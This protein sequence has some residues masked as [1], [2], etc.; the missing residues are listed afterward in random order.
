MAENF[1]KEKFGNITKIKVCTTT[2]DLNFD[3][4]T[5]PGTY[6]IYEDM[7]DG[8]SRIYFLT[9]DNSVTGACVKQTRI[10]CGTVE[11]RQTTTAGAWTAWEALSGGGSV[12]INLEN[13]EG[14]DSVVQTVCDPENENKPAPIATGTGAVALGRFNEAHGKCSMAV[15]YDNVV[16]GTYSFACGNGNFAEG[17]CTFV[18]GNKSKAQGSGAVAMG[19]ACVAEGDKSFAAGQNGASK[20]VGSCTIGCGNVASGDTSVAF[21][22]YNTVS[23]MYATSVGSRNVAE[24]RGSFIAG[25]Y[26]QT[27]ANWAAVFGVNNDYSDASNVFMIGCGRNSTYRSNVFEVSNKGIVR[28]KKTYATPSGAEVTL[29]LGDTAITETQL[30]T[31]LELLVS[32]ATDMGEIETALDS[33]IAIQNSLI[34]G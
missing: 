30:K 23:G 2:A 14:L 28:I 22:N 21:G 8:R 19:L 10:Y 12:S 7:G 11:T 31:L 1:F 18:S 34:G 9:V 16:N 5:E 17:N 3:T 33:I 4:Y 27:P 29:M 6:E 24:H 26:N 20:G 25:E 32:Y 15:N 13:G